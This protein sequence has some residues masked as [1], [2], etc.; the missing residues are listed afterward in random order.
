MLAQIAGYL[1][2]KTSSFVYTD[3]TRTLTLSDTVTTVSVYA[4]N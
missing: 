1:T 3:G 4:R 2:L